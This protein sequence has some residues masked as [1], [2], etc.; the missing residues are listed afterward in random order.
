MPYVP[1][2]LPS[3][4]LTLFV[5]YALFIAKRCVLQGHVVFLK[6]PEVFWEN[7]GGS[8]S[9]PLLPLQTFDIDI[10]DGARI[11][12]IRI[13]DGQVRYPTKTGAVKRIA[14]KIDVTTERNLVGEVKTGSQW[15]S[16]LERT[17]RCTH[18][19]VRPVGGRVEYS[20]A[21][22]SRC[23]RFAL[24]FVEKSCCRMEMQ[25]SRERLQNI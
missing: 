10:G 7:V 25:R 20:P 22:V 9:L 17:P 8:L 21:V 2:S 23:W 19:C 14:D 4:A 1:H 18:D 16:L 15:M 5:L 24:F 13:V 12:S 6:D 11:E 3:Y